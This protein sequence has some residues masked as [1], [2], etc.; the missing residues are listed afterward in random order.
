VKSSDLWDVAI[1]IGAGVAL[2]ARERGTEG[3]IAVPYR[4]TRGC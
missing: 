1:A 2:A 4:V 3:E